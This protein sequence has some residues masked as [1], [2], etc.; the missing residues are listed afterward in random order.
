LNAVIDEFKIEKVDEKI[1]QKL[2]V[3]KLLPWASD[4]AQAQ[5]LYHEAIR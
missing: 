2:S 5:Q 1:K 4:P 3:S